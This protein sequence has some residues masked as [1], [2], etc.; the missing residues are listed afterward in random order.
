MLTRAGASL[1]KRDPVDARIIEEV[2]S[3]TV[4]YGGEYGPGMGIIDSQSTVGGW[5]VLESVSAPQDQDHDG[6]PDAWEMAQGLDPAD[7]SDRNADSNGDGYTN[8]ERYL[9]GLC[10]GVGLPAAGR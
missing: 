9:N 2:R 8:L 10:E 4:M 1:P 5:P 3:G 7:P 6:M